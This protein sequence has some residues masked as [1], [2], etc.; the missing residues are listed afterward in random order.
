MSLHEIADQVSALNKAWAEYKDVNDKRYSSLEKRLGTGEV[1]EKLAKIDVAMDAAQ[2]SITAAEDALKARA[3]EIE[4]KVNQIHA[5]GISGGQTPVEQ[6]QNAILWNA[7]RTGQKASS[8]EDVNVA[9]YAEYLTAFNRFLRHSPD[10]QAMQKPEVRAAL[11]VGSDPDGGYWVPTELSSRILKRLHETSDMRSISSAVSISSDTLEMMND[12]NRGTSGG[13][14]AEKGTRPETNTPTV[15][16]QIITVHE[17]YAMPKATQRLLDDAVVDVE[18]W[19]AKKIAD[20][21]AFTE[22]TAFVTGNGVGK[23]RGFLDYGAAAVT[24]ADASRAW[25]V[26]Q[27]VPMGASGGFPLLSGAV[28]ASDCDAL[29]DAIYALK[30]AYRNGARWAM[31]R[32]TV[33]TVRKLRDENGHYHWQPGLQAGQPQS[34]LNYPIAEIEDMP[35]LAANSLSI[36]FGNFEEAYQIVDRQGIRVLRDNLTEKGFVKFYTTSRV[37]GDVVNFD[38]LKLVKAA[39]S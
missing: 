35:A 5:G 28:M 17:Q 36:A 6:R 24:T 14:V 26:L 31:A 8:L 15:G 16:K 33:A 10:S 38:A 9:E 25:G 21:L 11:S 30:P 27:Y 23:P 13:W 32:S 3:D 4:R 29:L 12:T 19:L 37:G 7:G 18:G 39:A 22:N 20:E 1:D 34:L 2:S